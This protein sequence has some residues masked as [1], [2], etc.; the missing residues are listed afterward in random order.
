MNQT[1]RS[2][3]NKHYFSTR[4]FWQ[5]LAVIA[6]IGFGQATECLAV[7]VKPTALTFTAVQGE[8]NPPTQ[9]LSMSRKRTSLITVTTSDN[10]PWLTVSPTTT[11]MTTNTT[12]TVSVNTSGLSAGTHNATITIKAGKATTTVPVTMI[13]SPPP[14]ATTA[15]L[16]WNAVTDPSLTGY[17]VKVGT[18]SGLYSRTITV[19]N[20]TSYTVDSLTNGTTYFFAV[21]SYNSAG[22]SPPSNEVSKS[23]Y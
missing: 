23:I 6:F 5:V 4:G 19:G 1:P 10:V 15:T 18:A 20:V 14:S 7:T 8:A 22:E 16:A 9:T 17:H 13:V 11:S 12:L 2:R 3:R 21:T